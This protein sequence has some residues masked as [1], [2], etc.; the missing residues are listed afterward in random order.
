VRKEF[1]VRSHSAFPEPLHGRSITGAQARSI[2]RF[3][4][5]KA[6]AGFG[7]GEYGGVWEACPGNGFHYLSAPV[8]T[9]MVYSHHL[10]A[11]QA[12]HADAFAGRIIG[13][14]TG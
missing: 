6:R 8:I 11:D 12:P 14:G 3:R 7:L 4:E 13:R 2:V 1:L 10:G 9:Q 5:E